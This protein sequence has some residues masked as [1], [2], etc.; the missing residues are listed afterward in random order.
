MHYRN[1]Q[2]CGADRFH[3]CE[4]AP[5]GQC[6]PW[7][8]LGTR[9]LAVS[10]LVLAAGPAHAQVTLAWKFQEGESFVVEN[11]EKTRQTLETKG[12]SH[13]QETSVTTISRFTVKQKSPKETVLEI[14]IEDIKSSPAAAP[15][16]KDL[17]KEVASKMKGAVFTVTLS[18]NHKIVK[19]EGFDEL[20]KRIADGKED[21]EK[22][23]RSRMSEEHLKKSLEEPYQFLPP[24]PVSKND[25]W[26]QDAVVPLGAFGSFKVVKTYSYQGKEAAGEKITFTSAMT[27]IRPGGE[28]ALVKVVKGNLKAE[29]GK[30]TFLFDSDKGRLI[31]GDNHVTIRGNLTIEFLD[32]QQEMNLVVDSSNSIRILP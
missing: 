4:A 17:D 30:G 6:L 32:E 15:G 12:K 11:V 3:S 8:S 2:R 20:I 1:H 21:I 22:L 26:K 18:P 5:R 14:K 25:T 10:L 27:Y 24:R 16:G 28:G 9:F 13:K 19:L 7:R 31:R 29:D 23:V